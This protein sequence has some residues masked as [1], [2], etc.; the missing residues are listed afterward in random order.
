[1]TYYIS[2]PPPNLLS[3]IVGAIVATAV[4]IGA[5]MVGMVALLVVA[6]VGVVLGIAIWL[7]VAWIKRQIRKSGMAP[8]AGV[9][10]DAGARTPPD[11]GRVI[12]AEYTVVSEPRDQPD[13]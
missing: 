11:S 6:G 1:M 10:S 5:F 2:P 7:R 13:N 9:Q 4:L 8:G 3:R 12:D